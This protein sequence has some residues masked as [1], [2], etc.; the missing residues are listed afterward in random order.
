MPRLSDIDRNFASYVDAD[1]LIYLDIAEHPEWYFGLKWGP[2]EGFYRM[3]AEYAEQV[4]TQVKSLAG[5]TAGGRLRFATDS[6]RVALKVSLQNIYASANMAYIG[7]AGFDLYECQEGAW[8]FCCSFSPEDGDDFTASWQFAEKKERKLLIHLP[9]YAGVRSLQLGLEPNSS[10]VSAPYAGQEPVVFYGSSITQGGCASRPGCS[11]TAIL[12][13]W[14][15]FDYRNLGF[16]SGARAEESMIRYLQQ[17]PMRILVLDYD[18]NAPNVD[19]LKRTHCLL[20]EKIRKALPDLPVILASAP[21]VNL[22]DEW[23]ARREIVYET[24]LYALGK[25]DKK[26]RFVDGSQMF[27]SSCAPVCMVDIYHPNDLG[28]YYMAQ[29]F[30]PAIREFL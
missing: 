1:G 28:M 2:G 25:G 26:I 22:N 30:E 23:C 24:Y 27:D 5:C 16:S 3:E 19:Y 11:Y 9:L 21:V 29:A 20:Y 14:M 15:D 17:Q 8:E 18:H 7:T 4:N 10:I 6:R 13:R 12:S